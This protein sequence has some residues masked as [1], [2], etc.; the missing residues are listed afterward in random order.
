MKLAVLA[1]AVVLASSVTASA[2]GRP[3]PGGGPLPPNPSAQRLL[4]VSLP[5]SGSWLADLDAYSSRVG[6]VPSVVS[7]F[8]DMEHYAWGTNWPP[9]KGAGNYDPSLNV[10]KYDHTSPV[11]SFPPNGY[12][13]SDKGRQRLELGG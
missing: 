12:G 4:G 6:R 7:M 8:R 2:L 9:T 13:L 5:W 10:D 3:K 1:A 11:G